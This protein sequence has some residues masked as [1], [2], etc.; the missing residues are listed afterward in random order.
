MHEQNNK[1]VIRGIRERG[2]EL[3]VS[4]DGRFDS[5]GHSALYGTYTLMDNDTNLIFATSLVK[6]I[7]KEIQ[8]DES[9]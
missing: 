6:V 1:E 5:P 8:Y 3:N 4:G 2:G 7:S 9:L